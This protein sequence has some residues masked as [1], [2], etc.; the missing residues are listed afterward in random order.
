M[1]ALAADQCSEVL[2]QWCKLAVCT[3]VQT[4]Q[5]AVISKDNE[6]QLPNTHTHTHLL[7]L[8]YKLS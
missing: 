1:L 2:K 7:P 3:T 6:N 5:E 8:Y 4:L